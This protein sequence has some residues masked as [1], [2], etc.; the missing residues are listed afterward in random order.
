LGLRLRQQ[1]INPTVA[2]NP[3]WL[4]FDEDSKSS[5]LRDDQKANRRFR[6]GKA[7]S[8]KSGTDEQKGS[9]I[10]Q[11]LLFVSERQAEHS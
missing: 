8:G 6:C 9:A 7:D 5:A 2:V 1:K 11:T 3:D 10:P 4:G